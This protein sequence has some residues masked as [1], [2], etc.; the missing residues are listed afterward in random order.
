MTRAEALAVAGAVASSNAQS[1][2]LSRPS[3]NGQITTQSDPITVR[4]DLSVTAPCPQGGNVKVTAHLTAVVDGATSSFTLDAS[5][6]DAPAACKVQ[7][8]AV[9]FTVDGDPSLSFESHVAVVNAKPSA[10]VVVKL[11]G[12]FK[13]TASDG[14]SGTCAIDFKETTDL[15]AKSRVREG[16][17]CGTTVKETVTWT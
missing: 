9:T 14:R 11:N 6:T 10:P 5:G 2:S 3:A 4:Q 15:N 17:V 1:T 13:W 7:H 12:A 8:D 16:T